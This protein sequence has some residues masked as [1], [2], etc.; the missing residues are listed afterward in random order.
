[1]SGDLELTLHRE[2]VMAS[3]LKGMIEQQTL[4]DFLGDF[5]LV[6]Q[7][8][9]DRHV[10]GQ[11]IVQSWKSTHSTRPILLQ[12]AVHDMLTTWCQ[13]RHMR[14]I[15]RS[16]LECSKIQLG[17]VVYMP[18]TASTG[19]SHIMFCP[20][21]KR[22]AMLP[23]RIDFIL[24]EPLET[25]SSSEPQRILILVR[26]FQELEAKDAVRDPF[27][28]HPI[29]G[30][31]GADLARLYYSKLGEDLCIIEPRDIVSHIA[32]CTYEDPEDAMRDDC[33]IILSLDLVG[34]MFVICI[35]R[36]ADL[37]LAQQKH[38]R[39]E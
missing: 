20:P 13:S 24:Q 2:F 33:I 39:F 25:K 28:N 9:L 14:P 26:S 3:R 30:R 22:A 21:G 32:V 23:G 7:D 27:R 37:A 31:H 4:R 5:G 1:M 11:S 34:R 15:S 18:Y 6:V 29:I 16:L 36:F 19:N 12:D 38:K 35:E 8:F 10:P 17:N